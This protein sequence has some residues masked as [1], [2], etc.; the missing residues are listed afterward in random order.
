M[1]TNGHVKFMVSID[2][3]ALLEIAFNGL[4][5]EPERVKTLGDA[6]QILKIYLK[7]KIEEMTGEEIEDS[8][9]VV[10]PIKSS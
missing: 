2:K 10:E 6:A 4:A 8:V 3:E 1:P 5:V 9:V 7:T